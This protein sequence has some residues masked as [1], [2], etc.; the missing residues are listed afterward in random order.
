MCNCF[1]VQEL[2]KKHSLRKRKYL[3]VFKTERVKDKD[4]MKVEEERS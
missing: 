1:G 4:T 2:E 3:T